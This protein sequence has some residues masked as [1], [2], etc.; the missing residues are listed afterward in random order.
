MTHRSWRALGLG[1]AVAV[2]AGVVGLA[3]PS[4]NQTGGGG[5]SSGPPS[6]ETPPGVPVIPVPPEASL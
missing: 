3:Q 1:A 4:S 5:E 6:S 2:A